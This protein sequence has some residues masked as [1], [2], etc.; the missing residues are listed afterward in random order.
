MWA[1]LMDRFGFKLIFN[2]VM[3]INLICTASIGYVG[4]NFWAYLVIL[5]LTMCCEGGM[6]SCFPAE[7]SKIFG[8]KVSI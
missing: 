8:H 2:I 1:S 3:I 7:S 6:F 4:N 5:S